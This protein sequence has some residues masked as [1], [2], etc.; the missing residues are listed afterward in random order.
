MIESCVISKR[1]SSFRNPCTKEVEIIFQS[2]HYKNKEKEMNTKLKLFFI[3]TLSII[4][5]ACTTTVSLNRDVVHQEKIQAV[6]LNKLNENVSI[7]LSGSTNGNSIGTAAGSVGGAA[8]GFLGSLLGSA[9]DAGIDS[10]R[11]K[12]FNS[13]KESTHV[14]SA[15]M[16]LQNALAH[17][18]EG[19]AFSDDV[20]INSEFDTSIK[21]PYLIPVL[22]PSV[23]MAPN[24][25]QINIFLSTSIT[26]KSIKNI[27]KQNQY[28]RVYT[29]EQ[30]LGSDGSTGSKQSNKQYWIDNPVVLRE[31]I[32]DGLYDVSKQF[33]D[34]FNAAFSE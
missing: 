1:I 23:V 31:K 13:I 3:L 30:V 20:V 10:S 21:K 25:S 18:L 19:N 29:S 34:D 28:Q 8:G 26:Q 17:N 6:N 33:S 9:I 27:E 5:S 24:Y 32:V 14:M 12:A 2:I 7:E 4:S 11:K 15:N 22:T 16:V